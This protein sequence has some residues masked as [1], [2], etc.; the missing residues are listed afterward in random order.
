M[1]EINYH[2]R[3]FKLLQ[4][5]ASAQANPVIF[6]YRQQGEIVWGTYENGSVKM[7]TFLATV[8]SEGHLD[9]HFQHLDQAGNLIKGQSHS[10]LMILPD[11]RYCL[12]ECFQV[13]HA[14]GTV[15]EGHS[16]V[17]EIVNS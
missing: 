7:G 15:S 11:G 16:V 9:L 10:R 8:S 5:T 1:A 12:D 17:E 6:H 2:D 3:Y 13:F 4:S 14:D